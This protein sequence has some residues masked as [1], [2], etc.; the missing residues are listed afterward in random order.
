[1]SVSDAVEVSWYKESD[2][3][4][5]ASADEITCTLTQILLSI[6]TSDDL[7]EYDIVWTTTDG[8]IEAG[9]E[10]MPQARVNSKGT[11]IATLKHKLAG[12][13]SEQE[14]TITQAADVP[15]IV[16]QDP[17]KLTC[18]REEVELSAIG[19]SEGINID[20]SWSGPGVIGSDTTITIMVNQAGVYTLSISDK[21]NGCVIMSSKEVLEDKTSPLA[22]ASVS[23]MLDCNTEQLTVSGAGSDEGN[24]FIYSWSVISAEGNIIGSSTERDVQVNEAGTYQLMVTNTTNGCVSMDEATVELNDNVVTG[25][26]IETTHPSCDLGNDGQIRIVSVDGGTMPFNYSFDGGISFVGMDN[27]SGLSHGEYEVIIQDANGCELKESVILDKPINFTVQLGED[28]KVNF[29]ELVFLQ[30]LVDLP[31][32][33][34]G[35]INWSPALDTA[36]ANTLYQEFRA[37]FLEQ[38]IRLTVMSNNGC[39]RADS[40]LIDAIFTENIYIPNVLYSESNIESN[41]VWYVYADPS[42]V[43]SIKRLEIYNRWGGLMFQR[44]DVPPSLNL[45]QDFGWDG[46][47]GDKA[48]PSG[49]Y[50]YFLDVEFVTG[51]SRTIRGDLSLIR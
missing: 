8:N 13:E 2:F 18:I 23:E 21:S 6:N 10:N 28:Q 48:A 35:N 45:D 44:T 22:V 5:S 30:A 32:S 31:D 34:I 51:E 9:D 46:R 37:D 29:G 36:N 27:A 12:C 17:E 26:E 39:E 15:V 49:V 50:S 47:I 3:T 11:Y 42:R 25:M 38:W 14:Y 24:N 7:S 1:M 16:F 4:L 20:Y 33:L 40:V 43:K 41:R 19:S